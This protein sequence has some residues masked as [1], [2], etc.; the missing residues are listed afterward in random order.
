[1][2]LKLIPVGLD[3]IKQDGESP[4][5]YIQLAPAHN[6]RQLEED[7][8]PAL[9]PNPVDVRYTAT[10]GQIPTAVGGIVRPGGGVRGEELLVGGD[11]LGAAANEADGLHAGVREEG[12]ARELGQTLDAV[13]QDNKRPLRTSLKNSSVA[14]T[15]V[16]GVRFKIQII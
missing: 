10:R 4:C 15:L 8:E 1:M 7:G 12:V 11:E 16:R 14:D 13:L 5:P 6:A 3:N 2:G 9:D